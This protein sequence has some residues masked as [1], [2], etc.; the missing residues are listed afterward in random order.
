MYTD[1]V[2]EMLVNEVGVATTNEDIPRLFTVPSGLRWL[3]LFRTHAT[4]D[5]SY[6][7]TC[8][9]AITFIIV[10]H[11]IDNVLFYCTEYPFS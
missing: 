5:C 7:Y 10:F 1:D 6:M 8:K 11:S 9:S 3:A 4:E 2:S